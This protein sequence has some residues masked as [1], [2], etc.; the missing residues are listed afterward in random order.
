MWKKLLLSQMQRTK[1]IKMECSLLRQNFTKFIGELLYSA[2]NGLSLESFHAVECGHRSREW[3]LQ[4]SHAGSVLLEM[5]CQRGEPEDRTTG[6]KKDLSKVR[7]NFGVRTQVYSLV[8][9]S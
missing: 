1:K 8:V 4:P 2:G 3:Y 6:R 7:T 9:N 5:M